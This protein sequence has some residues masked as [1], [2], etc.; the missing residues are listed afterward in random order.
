MEARAKDATLTV[1]VGGDQRATEKIRPILAAIANNIVYMGM[2]GNGQLAKLINQLLFN[3]SAAAMGEILPMAVKLGLDPEAVC[4]VVTTGTGQTFA[5]EFFHPHILQN[6][7]KPG[8]PLAEAYK[9]MEQR[10]RDKQSMKDPP[11]RIFRCHADLSDGPGS[12]SWEMKTKE[13]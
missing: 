4:R 10:R 1:M 2:S 9:D 7:F 5:L 11:A 13:R 12:G 8:Y 3:I 6:N